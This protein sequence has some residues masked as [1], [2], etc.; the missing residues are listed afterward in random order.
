MDILQILRDRATARSF[1]GQPVDRDAVDRIL[2]AARLAPS[3]KNRQAWRFIAVCDSE[4]KSVLQKACFGDERIGQCGCVIAACTTNLQYTMPN[5]QPSYPLD[6]A[7]A[8]SY[9][10]LQAAHEGLASVIW[11]TYEEG[12]VKSLLTVPFAM[13]VV[14]LLAVGHSSEEVEYSDRLPKQRVISYEHW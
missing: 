5:G 7:F 12:A 1:N 14:L 13:R 9:M 4:A 2:E 11:S 3:A 10:S 8:V 6:I